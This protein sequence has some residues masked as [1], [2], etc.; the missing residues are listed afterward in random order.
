MTP[1]LLEAS[2]ITLRRDNGTGSAIL[3]HLD[4]QVEP[5]EVVIIKGESGSG[6]TT[7][8]K[9]IAELNVYQEGEIRLNGQPSSSY[10][11]PN[12][13]TLVQYIPQRPSM[14]PGTPADFLEQCRS[15]AARK[16]RD[17]AL[18]AEGRTWPD[19]HDLAAEWGIEPTCWTRG[20][21][22]LSG[23]ESQRI[24]LAIA[25]G[26]GGAEVLLLDEPTSALDEV[27][28]KIVENSLVSMLPAAPI[29][30]PKGTGPKALVW[31]THS[32]EQA[33]RV[34]TRKVDITR[35]V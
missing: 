18:E 16:A 13:R 26:L 7:F 14:L 28:T 34:G 2:G 6:K 3:N 5:G 25:I 21:G 15:F 11:I 24:A 19:P 8:L 30:A 22:T 17:A 4:L 9:C 35:R 23:G 32:P 27:T 33:D 20:W 29:G 10:G 31:I 1:P 12:F